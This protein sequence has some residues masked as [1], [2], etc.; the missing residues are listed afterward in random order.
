[1]LWGTFRGLRFLGVFGVDLAYEIQLGK[2]TNTLALVHPVL[3]YLS[4]GISK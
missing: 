3:D 2:L 4:I 1:M